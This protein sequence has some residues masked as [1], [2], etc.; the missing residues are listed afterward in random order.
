MSAILVSIKILVWVYN[1]YTPPLINYIIFSDRNI[2]QIEL[3]QIVW[4]YVF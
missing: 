3:I 1:M 2:L 4:S